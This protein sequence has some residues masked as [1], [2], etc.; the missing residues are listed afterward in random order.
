MIQGQA[1]LDFAT[2][3]TVVNRTLTNRISQIPG[4][5]KPAIKTTIL[6]CSARCL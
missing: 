6:Q 2:E 3:E 5:T 4:R 1:H